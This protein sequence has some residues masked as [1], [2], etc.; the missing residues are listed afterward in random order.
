MKS[1]M[2]SRIVGIVVLLGLSAMAGCVE[3]EV[4]PQEEGVPPEDLDPSY[5][6]P[7][8]DDG[9]GGGGGGGSTTTSIFKSSVGVG[10]YGAIRDLKFEK[11]GSSN[12]TPLDGYYLIPADLNKG[13][14]GT[15]IYLTFTRDDSKVQARDHCGWGEGGY[16]TH[17][18]A[19]D[20]NWFDSGGYKGVCVGMGYPSTPIWEY[21]GD[22]VFGWPWKHPDLND[23]AGGRYIFAWQQKVA[24]TA[25]I[26]EVGVVS[27]S[28][29]S[30][31]CPSGW[32]RDNQDLNEGAGGDY[33]YFCYK[34]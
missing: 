34:K 7:P 6:Y 22:Y 13:A 18:F 8:I 33:I 27:G 5:Y 14:G 26:Q 9:G 31:Q 25:P 30:I 2:T 4:T 19:E 10:G 20:F 21:T 11:G 32:V 15:Y 24:G 3:T 1:A 29:S 16:V 17:L 12:Q 23:G 28:S